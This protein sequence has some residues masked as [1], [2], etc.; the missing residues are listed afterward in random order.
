MQKIANTDTHI[1]AVDTSKNRIYF[2]VSGKSL[3]E[4]PTFV[5]DWEQAQCLVSPGFTVLTDVSR[6]QQLTKDWVVTSVRLYK[7]LVLAGLAAVAE[8]LSEHVATRRHI[9]QVNRIS[10]NCYTKEEIFT[11]RKIA[12]AWLNRIS[13]RILKGK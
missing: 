8:I 3:L 2:T 6:I 10:K 5:Q 12:E 9:N 13:T 11:D 1:L 4:S 7:M